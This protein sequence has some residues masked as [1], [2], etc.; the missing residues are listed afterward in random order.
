MQQWRLHDVE[1]LVRQIIADDPFPAEAWSIL[2]TIYRMQGRI[3]EALTSLQR[4]VELEPTAVRHSRL[5]VTMQYAADASLSALRAE[6]EQWN[7][8][9]V[10]PLLPAA[11]PVAPASGASRPLRLGFLSADFCIH[12]TA[13]LTLGA[14]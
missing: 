13:F 5:L 9:Y 10:E 3:D 2:G 4:S 8:A 1:A 7:A 6:H 12:P 11:P 14:I